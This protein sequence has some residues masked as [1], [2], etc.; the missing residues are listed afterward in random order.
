[1]CPV[2][3]DPQP[4]V[5]WQKDSETIHLGWSRFRLTDSTLRIRD[6]E[7]ADTGIYVCKA[8]NGFGN[9]DVLFQVYVYPGQSPFHTVIHRRDQGNGRGLKERQDGRE[10]C[11]RSDRNSVPKERQRRGG[12]VRVRLSVGKVV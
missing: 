9:V 7:T 6:L 3:S 12:S 8:T 2:E 4:I 1:M 11:R 5:E 10:T